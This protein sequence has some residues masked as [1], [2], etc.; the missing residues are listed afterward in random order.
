MWSRM[1]I[2]H[3]MD[4][5]RKCRVQ[6][7]TSLLKK[8]GNILTSLPL[9][10]CNYVPILFHLQFSSGVS[11][12]VGRRKGCGSRKGNW[13]KVEIVFRAAFNGNVCACEGRKDYNA[14]TGSFNWKWYC[15]QI[16]THPHTLCLPMN[17]SK[18]EIWL[19]RRFMWQKMPGFIEER[20]DL[21]AKKEGTGSQSTKVSWVW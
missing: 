5:E 1:H 20:R 18:D 9:L 4:N 16:N 15:C 8:K 6:H 7:G 14:I 19:S 13:W 11:L 10:H 3:G 17:A 12:R 21:G 2:K